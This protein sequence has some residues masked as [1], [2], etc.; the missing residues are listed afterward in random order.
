MECIECKVANPE[1]N[2]F[3]GQCGTELGRSLE[4][5]I[6]KRGIRD[7][8]AIEFEIT[9]SVTARLMKW[10]GWLGSLTGRHRGVVWRTTGQELLRCPGGGA[11]RKR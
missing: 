8:K 6:R 5:T 4:E 9:E 10:G 3:C 11:Y 2:R 7:R 1:G